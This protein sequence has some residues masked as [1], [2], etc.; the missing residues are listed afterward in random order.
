MSA[1]SILLV[2]DDRNATE[3]MRHLLAKAGFKGALK[4]VQDPPAALHFLD[5]AIAGGTVPA[6]IVVDLTLPQMHGFDLVREL[7]RRLQA[8]PTFIAMISASDAAGDVQGAFASGADA[9]LEKFPSVA[10]LSHIREIVVTGA[11]LAETICRLRKP[12][13]ALASLRPGPDPR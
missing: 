7:R 4:A 6:L 8:A 12:N 11:R 13:S 2:D 5:Q 1:S 10:D 9:Y 3:L